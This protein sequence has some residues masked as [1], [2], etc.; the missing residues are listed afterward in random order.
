MEI[1]NLNLDDLII[2]VLARATIELTKNIEQRIDPDKQLP[3]HELAQA[4]HSI[5][6]TGGRILCAGLPPPSRRKLYME[7]NKQE[8]VGS[9]N[10]FLTGKEL[11]RPPDTNEAGLHYVDN[12]GAADAR[13]KYGWLL[14]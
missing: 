3:K 7:L 6:E 12:G 8:I 11:R 5:V 4:I 2:Q 9:D 1:N 13:Q 14:V 10:L